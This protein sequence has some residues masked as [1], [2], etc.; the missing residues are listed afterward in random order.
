VY[1][2][3]VLS[4]IWYPEPGDFTLKKACRYDKYVN[5][6]QGKGGREE[7]VGGENETFGDGSAPLSAS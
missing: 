2:N 1:E 5:F 7:G 4:L 3:L 6:T